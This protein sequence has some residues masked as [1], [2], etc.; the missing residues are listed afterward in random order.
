MG[1]IF[2]VKFINVL[3]YCE[4]EGLLLEEGVRKLRYEMF[5][6]IKDKIKV[7]KIVIGYNFND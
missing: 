5:Y 7:N 4:N 2:F 6:E 1:I 3:K